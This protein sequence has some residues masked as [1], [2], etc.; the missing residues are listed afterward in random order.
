MSIS[1]WRRVISSTAGLR[2]RAARSISTIALT[3]HFTLTIRRL[4]IDTD[5]TAKKRKAVCERTCRERE[6]QPA[7]KV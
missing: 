7:G 2:D 5:H 6:K 3:L 4:F 1:A